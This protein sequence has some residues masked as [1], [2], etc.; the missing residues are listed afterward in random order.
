[1]LTSVSNGMAP[2]E[3]SPPLRARLH[4]P[5]CHCVRCGF[6]RRRRVWVRGSSGRVVMRCGSS[7]TPASSRSCAGR[8]SRTSLDRPFGGCLIPSD[9]ATSCRRPVGPSESATRLN[10]I[11]P[12][13]SRIP[14]NCGFA[15]RQN[16]EERAERGTAP[17]YLRI[18]R[19][20][21]MLLMTGWFCP[22][23]RRDLR[24][25]GCW[26]ESRGRGRDVRGH[27]SIG[28]YH[29]SAGCL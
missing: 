11:V 9:S 23:K 16:R 7:A 2:G 6:S 8:R 17:A 14:L 15:I 26:C 3:P 13:V 25:R 18:D 22:A 24:V 20:E 10:P 12:A 29:S 1:V 21:S 27:S 19:M 4:R 28:P 5:V